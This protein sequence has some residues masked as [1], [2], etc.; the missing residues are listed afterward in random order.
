MT[1]PVKL[2]GRGPTDLRSSVS[3]FLA[4][5]VPTMIE[6]ARVDWGLDEYQLPLPLEYNG[7]DPIAMNKLPGVGFI[8]NNDRGHQP[9]D[10][11]STAQIEMQV[12]Y[13][14]RIFVVVG[15]PM[16]IEG[17]LEREPR[18]TCI[19]L[20]DDMTSIVKQCLLSTPSCRDSRV[21]MDAASLVTDYHE[22]FAKSTQSQVWRAA[23]VLSADFQF[24]Q[25][26]R[27][28][29][30]GVPGLPN[31]FDVQTQRLS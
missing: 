20:R 1:S 5:E 19:R 7:N 18:D 24:E 8:T 28:Y 30:T 12:M 4:A 22:A 9:V 6:I 23:A 16:T 2:L 3:A 10:M 13:S 17:K 26:T 27:P 31:V 15:T 29:T 14:L 25:Y 21:Q 11:T